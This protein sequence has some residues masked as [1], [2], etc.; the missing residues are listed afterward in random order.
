MKRFALFALA[1]LTT[2]APSAFADGL[3]AT[4]S[5]ERVIVEKSVDGTETV[6][7]GP[8]D[9]VAPG[10]EVFYN[11]D[12]SNKSEDAATNVQLVMPVPSEVSY[13]ENSA[14][15][16]GA[17]IAFSV[18]GGKTFSQRGALKVTID[19]EERLA[20]ADQIT[21]IRWSY[22]EDIEPGAEG[23]VGYLAVLK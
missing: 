11:L 19:G 12:Y 23:G 6:R 9:S 10:D 13:V 3:V 16:E 7:F 22:A 2:F 8:A 14:T 17:E 20:K 18:D 21:H 4:Q 5:V 1:A 15:G